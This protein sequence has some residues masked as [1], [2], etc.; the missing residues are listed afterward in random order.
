MEQKKK[1]P[2]SLFDFYSTLLFIFTLEFF[3]C[4]FKSE[5]IHPSSLEEH[6]EKVCNCKLFYFIDMIVRKF[7]CKFYFSNCMFINLSEG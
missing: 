1:T 7:T 6:P 5:E 2:R 3:V 4:F